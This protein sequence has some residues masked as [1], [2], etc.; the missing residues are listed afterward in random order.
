MNATFYVYK[1]LLFLFGVSRDGTGGIVTLLCPGWCGIRFR[2]GAGNFSFLQQSRPDQ[3]P[4]QLPVW[5][6]PRVPTM[7]V[8]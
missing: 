4:T 2:A 6:L 8:K 1:A 3:G 7:G 5:W